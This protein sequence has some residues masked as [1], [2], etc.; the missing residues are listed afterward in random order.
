ME[1]PP[2]VG[3]NVGLALGLALGKNVV[4]K[5]EKEMVELMGKSMPSMYPV[6]Q[7]FVSPAKAPVGPA[8]PNNKII[9]TFA[10]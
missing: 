9:V 4:F 6:W 3:D 1:G 2:V 10:F 7:M 8:L 5:N